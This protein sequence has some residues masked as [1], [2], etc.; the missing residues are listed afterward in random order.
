[1]RHRL[2]VVLVLM[3]A[4]ST[5]L[6]TSSA[7]GRLQTEDTWTIAPGET[8]EVSV[9]ANRRAIR[10]T[11]ESFV[12]ISAEVVGTTFDDAGLEDA[13]SGA[14]DIDIVVTFGELPDRVNGAFGSRRYSDWHERCDRDECTVPLTFTNEGT[15]TAE[16][17]ATPTVIDYGN[18][19]LICGSTG[20]YP[21]SA[22]LEIVP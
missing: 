13:G 1:M 15:R 6:A 11:D 17:T 16:V 8:V 19:G 20:D 9:V 7:E 14:L 4:S 18:A 22:T 2:S 10:P 5:L 21:D 3:L 12:E